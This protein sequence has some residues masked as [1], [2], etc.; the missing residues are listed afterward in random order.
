MMKSP[1]QGKAVWDDIA[2]TKF[3]IAYWEFILNLFFW[4][5]FLLF[6]TNLNSSYVLSLDIFSI[7]TQ[8]G[9]CNFFIKKDDWSAFANRKLKYY[10]VLKSVIYTS[11]FELKH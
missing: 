5:Y 7:I 11:D 6:K 4:P 2:C 3:S 10:L 8:W 1:P 9:I